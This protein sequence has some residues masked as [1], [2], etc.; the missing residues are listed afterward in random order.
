MEYVFIVNP[1]AGKNEKGMELIPNIEK[2]CQDK[3]IKYQIHVSKGAHDIK[4]FVQSLCQ[5]NNHYRFYAIGGDGTL[6]NVING[7]IG[8]PNV[9]V[10]VIPL[11]TGNDFIK[12]FNVSL[13]NYFDIEKQIY[14]KTNH[15]DLIKFEDTYAINLCNIGF[16]ANVAV[17]M[18]KFKKMP[19]ISNHI[20]YYLS[21]LFN[22]TKK[23]GQ[24]LTI[25]VDD[26]LFYDGKVIMC[27]IGNGK[28]CG[29]G[30]Y[31]TP[32]ALVNDGLFDLVIVTPTSRLKLAPFM[33][34]IKKGTHIYH[35]KTKN[36]V[37]F[38][39]GKDICISSPNSINL[40]IDGEGFKI[41]DAKFS[42]ANYQTKFILPL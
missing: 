28:C 36:N 34:N 22:L 24:H 4:N 31:V 25:K 8:Y 9:E 12:N 14:G 5:T 30:F 6:N 37:R 11:G 42:L 27:S 29:G 10:G 33:D 39:Q 38:M 19:L 32:H 17:D 40:V 20:A 7:T 26:Q 35:K 41:K 23:L 15:I 1:K 21:V 3:N 16:D 2:T 13:D 18:P